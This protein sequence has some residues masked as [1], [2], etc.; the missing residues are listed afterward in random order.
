[1][2][3]LIIFVVCTI[4]L[5]ASCVNAAEITVKMNA[6]TADGVGVIIGTV[7]FQDTPKGLKIWPN[8]SDLTEGQ[9]GFHVHENAGC[10]AKEQSGKL[11]AG[12]AAGGHFDPGK[13][14]KHTGPDGMG[15]LGDLP[16]LYVN[17]KGQATRT[18]FASR[19][20]TSDLENRAIVV[21]AGG[22][23]YLDEPSS[24]GGGGPRVA[25]GVVIYK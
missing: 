17:E 9:H 3:R 8:L 19:L 25:C 21:H 1:M 5:G 20:K 22:D 10:G 23:N 11:V 13:T 18:S 16:V 2:N 12:L 7:A 15:H 24:L 6:I 14:G 4:L